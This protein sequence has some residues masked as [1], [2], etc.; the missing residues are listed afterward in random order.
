VTAQHDNGDRDE[1]SQLLIT[2]R[3]DRSQM[4]AAAESGLSQA[5]I[6]RAERGRFPLAPDD[7]DSYARALGATA[8]QRRRLVALAA[9]RAAGHTTGRVALVRVAAAIQERIERLEGAATIV[10]GWQP[11]LVPGV[12]QTP[13]YTAALLAGDG[14]GDPGPSW[15]AARRA[16]VAAVA[17]LGR[18]WHVLMSEAA[19]R[20][21]LGS[22]ALMIA[23]VEQLIA[24]SEL[25]Q[26]RLGVVELASPKPF[27]SPR[28][29]H[30]YAGAGR[31]TVCVATD[32]GTSFVDDPADV[33]H[34]AGQFAR[35]DAIARYGDD[36]RSVLARLAD[37]LHQST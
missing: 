10:R 8:Q 18:E 36:A 1:L 34:F 25:P 35:L 24:L 2:L 19:V 9:A 17:E 5:K 31:D 26:V 27:P 14:E 13:E 16:R 23:Q 7:A 3:G 37:D 20:W 12:L 4:R 15:W 29:F 30:I 6:S 21:T 22:R 32:V 33:A 11:D 28:A